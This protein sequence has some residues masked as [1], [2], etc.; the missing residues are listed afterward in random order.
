MFPAVF[1]IFIHFPGDRACIKDYVFIDPPYNTG[2]N[3]F[4]YPDSFE[5]TPET[6][7]LAAGIEID[8]AERILNLKGKST[9]S[10]WLTFMFPRLFLAR[11]LLKDDGVIFISIDDNEQA[12]LKLLCDEIFGEINFINQISVKTKPTAGASGGGEDK[13]LKKNIEYI[14]CYV[15]NIEAFERFN[16]VYEEQDLFELI[17]EMKEEGKSWKYT[18]VLYSFGERTFFKDIKDGKGEDIKI[19]KH[20]N[21]VFKTINELAA[22]LAETKN[23]SLEDARK[24][25]HFE[26]F[27]YI[28][29]DTNAQSS[30]RQRVLDATDTEDTFYSIEYYPQTGRNKGKL[31]TLYYKG[32]NKDLI[33]W[34]KDVAYKTDDNIFKKEKL[35]TLWDNFNWNNVTKEGSIKYSNGKKP[36]A[37]IN[38][39]LEMCTSDDENDI[40]LD[41]FSGSASTAHSVIH[42]NSLSGKGNRRFIMV[43]IPENLDEMLE[44]STSTNKKDIQELIDLLDSIQKP[45]LLSEVG[46]ERI[47]RA[48]TKIKE[49]TNADIDYGFKIY[50]LNTPNQNSLDKITDFDSVSEIIMDNMLELFAFNNVE[51]VET[52]LQM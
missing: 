4:V 28:F 22:E 21:V 13:K 39:L 6:L 46:I 20:E 29:R 40:V 12:N 36:I 47:K 32:R 42:Q 10:A 19:Y 27:D 26:Y 35:G 49:E 2:N 43:Q 38:Q 5:Y 15:K 51:S 31:T 11:D 1:A 37:L 23:I 25:I 14:L 45:H 16:E 41:F 33:A 7:S 30:I 24:E 52:I 9:H 50:N 48:A 3:D 17:E 44:K 18:R 8:E 34:L